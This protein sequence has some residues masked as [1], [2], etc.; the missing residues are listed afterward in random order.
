LI[1]MGI[2][3]YLVRKIKFD[4]APF[5]IAL[6][7]GPMMETAVRESLYISRGDISIFITRPIS[8]IMIGILVIL[9]LLPVIWKLLRITRKWLQIS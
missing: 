2:I 6:V 4:V 3:G 8:G 5:V 9:L 7:L 1:V